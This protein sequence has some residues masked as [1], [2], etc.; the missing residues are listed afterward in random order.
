MQTKAELTRR[1]LI[2]SGL[3]QGVG[4][5]WRARQ[6]ANAVGC[7]GWVR[8]DWD[9]SV[10]MEIQGTEAAIDRVIESL[11]RSLYIR[12]DRVEIKKL[13]TDTYES[14]FRTEMDY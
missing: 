1:H 10:T 5:R 8:N 2:F 12:I 6:A 14:S 7:T 11:N 9:G 13:P 4:F 3:V